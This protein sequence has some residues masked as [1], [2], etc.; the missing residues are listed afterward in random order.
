V[1]PRTSA[2]PPLA[3]VL[4]RG[5]L[6]FSLLAIFPLFLIYEIGVAFAPVMNGVDFVSRNLLALVEHDRGRYLLVHGGLAAAFVVYLWFSRGSRHAARGQLGR[7]LLE[8]AIYALTLGSFILFVMHRVLGITPDLSTTALSNLL[9]S[10]GAGVH[11]ELVFRLGAC[12]GGAALLR[13]ARVSHG[14]SVATAA[15][16]SSV[17]FSA[18]HHLGA[19]GEPW[20][21][22]TFVFRLLAGLL[23]A[24]I[25]YYRSLAH[26]VYTH[27]LYD[28]YVLVLR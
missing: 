10:I 22:D 6:R 12:A 17:L 2:R 7:L 15:L 5:D 21:L 16:L 14:A 1:S 27:A 25:F 3:A 18:A 13:L 4:G 9:L 8:S 26:A 19:A 20:V 24:A 11:E 23:F 28:V